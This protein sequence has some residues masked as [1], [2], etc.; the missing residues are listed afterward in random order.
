MELR[1][2]A[3]LEREFGFEEW[4]FT[5]IE[6]DACTPMFIVALFK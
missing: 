1:F 6:R 3:I 4:N 2:E 5:R